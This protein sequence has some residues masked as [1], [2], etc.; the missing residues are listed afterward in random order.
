MFEQLTVGYQVQER[1]TFAC[2]SRG[3]ELEGWGECATGFL[4]LT[5]KT[6][7][8]PG[9]TTIKKMTVKMTQARLKQI[10]KAVFFRLAA[11]W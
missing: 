2:A 5:R 6:Y 10:T 11:V 4:E 3:G 9:L 1:R 7:P 8:L